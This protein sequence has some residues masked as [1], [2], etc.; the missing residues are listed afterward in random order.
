M[1]FRKVF[2]IG[3]ATAAGIALCPPFDSATSKEGARNLELRPSL[4]DKLPSIALLPSPATE[5]AEAAATSIAQAAGSNEPAIRQLEAKG[6]QNV[7]GLVR[8]GDNFI[9]Q[10]KDQ[11]G[12]KVR[13]VMNAR[14]GEIVGLS[15]IMKKK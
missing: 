9:A 10:A 12:V 4:V 13:V 6:F 2:F 8:R 14:T 5:A 1:H 15:R 7:S 11:N 3:L